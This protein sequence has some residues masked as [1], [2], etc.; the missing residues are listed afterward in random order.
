MRKALFFLGVLNDSD[1]D[2]LIA[3]GNRTDIAAGSILIH[4]GQPIEFMF[5]ILDGLF[6]VSTSAAPG[7]DI[8][9]LK[10]GEV[11]GELSFLD[12]RPPSASVRAIEK[13]SVLAI[14]KVRL[15]D[16]LEADVAFASRFY[17]ALGV[18][19]SDR[20]RSTIGLLGYGG[21]R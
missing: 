2:W 20:L 17:R 11:L 13:S 9:R 12:S 10:S 16:K 21:T 18:F 15:M 8:A 4:Q 19:L 5:I 3:Q 14:S 1:L 7:K 6:A